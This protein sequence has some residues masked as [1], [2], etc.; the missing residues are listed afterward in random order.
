LPES[1]HPYSDN[2]D[3]TWSYTLAG[4]PSAIDVTFDAQTWVESDYDY[5]Y[6]MT[7]AGAPISGSP[8][9]GASLAGRTVRV[10]GATV[11]VRLTSDGS[12]TGYGF[13]I[14]RVVAA[15]G[16][17]G[18]LTPAR[19]LV[20]TWRTPSPVAFTYQTDFCGVGQ[21][22][23]RA[24]WNVTWIIT[25]VAGFTNVIDIEMRYTRGSMTPIGNC[26]P[27]GWVPFV[28][29][30]F[31]RGAVNGSR[32]GRS[33][34]STNRTISFTGSVTTDTIEVTWIHWECLIYC[35]G[36]FTAEHALK[37]VRQR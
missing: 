19:D 23:G 21:Q 35:F 34:S 20:G 14:T 9:T 26:Q 2:S 16:T 1:P 15:G 7:G 10:Q 4:N 28:S 13:R 12:L 27:N 33:E 32:I 36:E 8:F 25:A 11:R 31:L 3:T 29:P 18:P 5:I 6:V 17:E 24:L 37:L 30:T 22:V